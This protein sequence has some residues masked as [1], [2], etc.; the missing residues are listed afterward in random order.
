LNPTWVTILVGLLSGV[1]G[2]ALTTL[3]RISHERAAELRGRMLDAADAFA[4]ASAAAFHAATQWEMYV[5][6]VPADQALVD[7]DEE[8]TPEIAD[9]KNKLRLAVND[10]QVRAA[11]VGLLFGPDSDA[12]GATTDLITWMRDAETAL[13]T[14]PNSARDGEVQQELQHSLRMAVG[15]L[16][17][18]SRTGMEQL[19]DTWPRRTRRRI[20]RRRTNP[21]FPG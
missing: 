15:M 5:V 3:L 14:K 1:V 12:V 18:F 6:G 13:R 21:L 7:A 19:R 17:R 11:R 10:A 16:E 4:V 2:S 8:W 9:L 20:W